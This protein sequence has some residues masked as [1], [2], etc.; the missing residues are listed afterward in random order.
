MSYTQENR[1]IAINTPLGTDVL[2]LTGCHGIEGISDLFS[3]ELDLLSE[4][5][6][7]TFED[8]IGKNVAVSIILADGDKRFFNGIISS[9][10][11][12]RGGGEA[13]GDTHFSHYTATMVPWLW[14]LTRTAD[15]RIFQ[16]LSVPDIVEKI[17]TEKEFL[18]YK[19]LLNDSYD[20][21]DYC[22]QYRETDFNF[23]SRLLEEEGICYF[24]EHEEKKHTL[25]LADASD[26]FKPC[27]KQ[28]S[29]RYQISAGGWLEEDVITSLEKMQEIRPA[30][31]SINDFNFEI[32]G[33]DM[34]VDVSTKQMLGPGEREIY[35]Y[36]GLYTKKAQGERLTTIRMEEEE[37]KITTITGSSDCRAFTS[38]YRFDL[39]EYFR[40]DMNNKPYV[41]TSVNHGAT[42]PVGGSGQES[43][44]SYANSFTCI[45]FDVPYRPP[46][47]TPKPVVEG[48]Q[49]AIVVGPAGEEIYTDEHGRIK[50]QFHWD[51]EG[52][53]NENSSCWIRVSQVWAGAG[54]GAMH[55]PRIGQEVIVDFL[56]G[57]PDRPII[58]GRVYHG[59]NT[60]PYSLPDEKTKSTIKSDS[61]LG[62]GGSNEIRFEDKKGEEEVYLHGQKDWTI[63]IE[64]DKNQTV[65]HDETLSV[66]ND[67]TIEIGANHTESIGANMSLSVGK[68]KTETV[69]INTAETIGAAK[70]LT[71]GAAY[72]VTVGAAMNETVGG[73]KMEEVGAYKMEAVGGK[74]SETIGGSKNLSTGKD[75][76]ETVGK[77][78][79]V[80][81]NKD[82][83]EKVGGKH[84]EQ[85]SKEYAVNAKKI[86]L[87]AEDQIVLK[88]GKAEI[89]MKKNG[90]IMVKGKKIQIK[91]SGD[92]IIK[93][94]KIKEN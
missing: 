19:L 2:L 91:G 69:T 83:T 56:E 86:Q 78:Q 34:K 65:G 6:N 27:P 13:G 87:M 28:E 41:M 64:N 92:V 72:Q 43:G 45:P 7:I 5:H 40:E 75:L 22:V 37:T 48:A 23:I 88:T 74:K 11:Q 59:T 76:T 57:D 3:F 9:F 49:T 89:V 60:P 50:V 63:A 31:Y 17:F 12:G 14:L 26:K 46:R 35:D 42:E 32:P 20:K 24:F 90:D 62:G 67:K 85:V 81:I 80:T 10:S 82:L 73:A 16:K 51:R 70:E 1:L 53:N 52:E 54:W 38:G 61:S 8:I 36:P 30:K 15:S 33:T 84:T 71:I 29:A 4:N 39:L 55:I 68:N 94:S 66:G 21:R 47:L 58:T 79:S 44:Q 18:D 25:I 93:G 77:S